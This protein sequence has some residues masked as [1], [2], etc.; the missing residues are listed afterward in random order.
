MTDANTSRSFRINL[1]RLWLAAAV[2]RTAFFA[3]IVG[4]IRLVGREVDWLGSGA[5]RSC[6]RCSGWCT[7]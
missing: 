2:A 4:V 5:S 6:R 1:V 3:L 7:R